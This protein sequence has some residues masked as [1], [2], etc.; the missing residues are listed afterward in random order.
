MLNTAEHAI[1]TNTSWLSEISASIKLAIPLILANLAQHALIMTD[2]LMIGW[3]GPDALAASMLAF[4]IYFNLTI[5]SIGLLGAVP[6]LVAYQLGRDPFSVREIRRT[7]RQGLWIT[8]TL[9]VPFWIILWNCESI[10]VTLGQDPVL[11]HEATLYMR[12]LQWGLLPQLFYVTL[13]SFCA[14]MERPLWGLLVN[15]LAAILNALA[16]WCLI[17]GHF[18]FPRLELV[19]AGIASTV[20]SCFMLGSMAL[21]VSTHRHFR[22]YHLFKHLWKADWSCYNKVWRLGLPIGTLLILET[23]MFGAVV[24]LMGLISASALAAHSIAV[25]IAMASFMIPLGISQAAAIRVGHAFG[26]QDKDAV[27]RSGWASLIIGCHVTILM[28][29]L[30]LTIP[31][32]LINA[33]IDRDALANKQ[34]FSLAMSYLFIAALLQLLDGTQVICAGMLRG[35]RDTRIPMIYAGISY[36]IIGLG[37]GSIL[38][39]WIGLKGLGL[40]IGMTI[41]LGTMIGLLLYRWF[42]QTRWK[43]DHAHHHPLLQLP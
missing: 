18:G 2:M 31:D 42:S 17:F 6:V 14:A 34:T 26:A 8:S 33:F 4:N 3:L 32:I 12:A 21:I 22:R 36:W 25:Q 38:A 13:R 10:L 1:S 7:V 20:S 29:L 15:V 9:I 23:G 43:S 19:G 11:S 37:S 28:A 5:F 40:W 41:G 16:N 39:F 27:H 30:I 24:M 35:L